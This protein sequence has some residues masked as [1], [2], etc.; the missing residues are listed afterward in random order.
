MP[1]VLSRSK[2]KV[3]K[4]DAGY[5]L[6]GASLMRTGVQTYLNPDGST[7]KEYRPA[8]EVFHPD[9]LATLKLLPVTSGHPKEF[10]TPE[11]TKELSI[12]TLGENIQRDGQWAKALIRISDAGALSE[13]DQGIEE[14]SMGYRRDQDW[15]PGISPEGEAYDCVQRKIRYNHVA[16]VENGR[17]GS[18]LIMDAAELIPTPKETKP[19]EN[20]TVNSVSFEVEP[21]L[22]QAYA[23]EKLVTDGLLEVA[24]SEN[25]KEKARADQAEAD[26]SKAKEVADAALAP[27]VVKE[28]VA[29]RIKLE[30]LAG[31]VLDS[32]DKLPE[33]SASDIYKA[34]ILKDCPGATEVEDATEGY[35]KA[36][37][38]HVMD[39]QPEPKDAL[40]LA[41]EATDVALSTAPK[42]NMA[43]VREAMIARNKERAAASLKGAN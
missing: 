22:A 12:G 28:A 39:S 36:R 8:D 16:L 4:T 38:R 42:G 9:S 13:I 21:K 30:R 19:V 23:A 40:D 7:R 6:T 11:N 17:A 26:L 20:I 15:T 2:A 3:S 34:V 27:D 1:K 18:H 10:L 25:D 5:L 35:L 37:F 24:V 43:T 31:I 41:K 14:I 29:E 32:A 33:M